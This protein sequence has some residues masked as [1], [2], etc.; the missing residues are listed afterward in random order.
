MI[1]F[2]EFF[3]LEKT[4]NLSN[5]RASLFLLPFVVLSFSSIGLAQSDARLEPTYE[6]TLHV[7]IGS[8]DA[9]PRAALPSSLSAVTKHLK[10][11][12]SFSNYSLANTF[13]G[14][15]SNTGNLEY[16]SVSNILGQETDAGSPTFFEWSLGPIRSMPNG[17]Q[18]LGFRFG[19]RVPIQTAAMKDGGGVNPIVGYEP[20]GLTMS[21]IG[22]P[23]DTPTLVG[24]ISLP[25]TTG[26]IFL[27]AT[28]RAAEL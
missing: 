24:T 8:N 26:T 7:V 22:L 13:I 27:V 6:I 18:A 12:F 14:R 3:P 9:G 1:R 19:A 5:L 17:I 15:V 21:M 11:N 2:P 10:N 23:F 20:I 16:K 25:K 28:V 4:M